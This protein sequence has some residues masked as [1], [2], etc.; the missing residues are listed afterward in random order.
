YILHIESVREG[1]QS[2]GLRKYGSSFPEA[3]CFTIVFRGKRKNLD[4]AA[5]TAEEAQRWVRGLT[6]LMARAEAMSQ[7]EKLEQ[8]PFQ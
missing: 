6:K 5:Q 3:Q 7:R 8:Y 4:L 1:Y 2:E